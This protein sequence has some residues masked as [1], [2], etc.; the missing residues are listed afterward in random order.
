M[1][2]YEVNLSVDA[3]IANEYASWLREHIR[4]MLQGDGFESA[5]WY[6]PDDQAGDQS[7][8]QRHWTV[9]YHVSDRKHLQDYLEHRAEAMRT[10]GL[11]RFE[12]RFQADRRVL[13]Q[14][15]VFSSTAQGEAS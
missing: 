5:A 10:S 15:H 8:D 14:N 3:D 6:T 9:H 2:I 11:E 13:E 7:G 12:G 4:E 1:L